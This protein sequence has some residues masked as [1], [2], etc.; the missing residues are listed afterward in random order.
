MARLGLL[1][2]TGLT[3]VA[4]VALSPSPAARTPEPAPA[5]SFGQ[6]IA[7]LGDNRLRLSKQPGTVVFRPD[8]RA[9]AATPEQSSAVVEWDAETGRELRRYADPDRPARNLTALGY[10]P[11][12]RRLVVDADYNW[13][14]VFDTATGRVVSR[15]S[16][17]RNLVILPD[18]LTIAGR[19]TDR[20]LTVWDLETGRPVRTF[21][22]GA[23][24]GVWVSPDGKW[25]AAGAD[26]AEVWVGPAD[27]SGPGRTYVLPGAETEG[28]VEAAWGRPDRVVLFRDRRLEAYDPATGVRTAAGELP[29]GGRVRLAF[30]DVEGRF[31]LQQFGAGD[32]VEYDP[33]ILRPVVGGRAYPV[34]DRWP[35]VSRDGSKRAELHGHAVRLLDAKTGQ[36]LHPDLDAQPTSPADVIRFSADSCRMLTAGYTAVRVWEP[37]SRKPLRALDADYF[38]HQ[39]LHLSPDGRW[40][41]GIAGSTGY[42]PLVVRD[43]ATGGEVFRDPPPNGRV[44]MRRVIGFDPAGRVWLAGLGTGEITCREVPSG[45][46]VQ[47]TPGIDQTPYARLSPDGRKLAV[48]GWKAFAVRGTDPA[49]AW[50]VIEQ[51][52][53][54]Q[55]GGCGLDEP[56]CPVPVAFSPDG[57]R[58][59][60]SRGVWDITGRSMLRRRSS[61]GTG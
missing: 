44:S 34:P 48:A 43:A 46:L 30:R 35:V 22:T 49:A 32:A 59:F 20:R 58:L 8:G 38:A 53:G 47:T 3:L 24:G 37:P 56:P 14:V 45:R 52:P 36:P 40:V 54:R 11:D 60:T 19:G 28:D 51:Y 61:A 39:D 16:H 55:P 23:F 15:F 12:G 4:F 5:V 33:D 26:K 50:Q 13:V 10:T 6:Q 1:L 57:K 9:V 17:F 29:E 27:G 25:L 2:F 21:P 41:V 42:Y 18:G 7:R 31:Y